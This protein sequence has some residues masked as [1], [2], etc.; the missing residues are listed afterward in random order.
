MEWL[1]DIQIS[2][3]VSLFSCLSMANKKISIWRRESCVA[4]NCAFLHFNKCGIELNNFKGFPE[5][6]DSTISRTSNS[7]QFLLSL[8]LTMAMTTRIIYHHLHLMH[9]VNGYPVYPCISCSWREAS[10]PSLLPPLPF[11]SIPFPIPS[12]L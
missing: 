4:H 11:P 7:M 10:T 3:V 9:Q 5:F 1:W 6:K 12:F 8:W 2:D